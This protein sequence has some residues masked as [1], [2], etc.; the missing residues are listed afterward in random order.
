[1]PAEVFHHRYLNHP[2]IIKLLAHHVFD[3]NHVLVLERPSLCTDLFEHL[4]EQDSLSEEE[5]KEI[6]RQLLSAV[7]YLDGKNIIHHDLKSENILLDLSNDE[8]KVKV[9]D[10]GLSRFYTEEPITKFFG[11]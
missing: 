9:I 3:G 8:K 7:Q 6:F 11:E 1:M 2:N 5:S 10:F 4:F